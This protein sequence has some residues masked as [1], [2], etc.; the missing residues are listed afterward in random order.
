MK[1]L[2]YIL[3]VLLVFNQKTF[4]VCP[5]HIQQV[6]IVD[7]RCPDGT[8]DVIF[9][10]LISWDFP[11]NSSTLAV[12]GV[13]TGVTTML[14]PTSFTNAPNNSPGSITFTVTSG[15]GAVSSSPINFNINDGGCYNEQ[16][17]IPPFCIPDFSCSITHRTPIPSL[18]TGC[19]ED[20]LNFDIINGCVLPAGTTVSWDF[21][22]GSPVSSI[23]SHVYM[24]ANVYNVTLTITYPN[25]TPLEIVHQVTIE[26]CCPGCITSFTPLPGERY[27][28]SAWVK[29]DVP[30][31]VLT[32][33]NPIIELDF[34]NPVPG[35]ILGPFKAKGKIIDGWQ[36]IEEII[37]I[38][39]NSWY[40]DIKLMNNGTNQVYFDDVRVSP[41]N[42]SMKT[43]VYDPVTLRLA[44]ELDE[45][46]YATFY[47]YDE[48]GKLIRVKKETER[49]IE[50][51]QESRSSSYKKSKKNWN[52]TIKDKDSNFE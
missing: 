52:T 46:N 5:V 7:N 37:V 42:S 24:T 20:V 10:Y 43:F 21:G 18:C 22:D 27:V 14:N 2:I 29:E 9:N 50:T 1:K 28:I 40:V 51:V 16:F 4:G 3:I 32:Y 17:T 15:N 31:Q 49:G 25:C 12:S 26:V 8:G 36:K 30:N 13:P 33:N 48:E 11:P 19:E 44:A 6:S 45:N 23:G 39:L 35:T 47:Q 34:H 38:P 41:F